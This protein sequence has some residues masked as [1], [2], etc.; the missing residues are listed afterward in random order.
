[1]N[2]PELIESFLGLSPV[3]QLGL[4]GLGAVAIQQLRQGYIGRVGVFGS[5]VVIWQ[6]AYPVWGTLHPYLKMYSIVA[7]LFGVG[8]MAAYLTGTSLPSAYYKI[9]LLLFGG[10]PLIFVIV[11]G[12]PT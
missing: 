7:G 5:A 6:Y 12:F 8:G 3:V 11:F 1:M 10:I 2:P 9:A 4:L